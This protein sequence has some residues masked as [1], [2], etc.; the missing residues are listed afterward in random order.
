MIKATVEANSAHHYAVAD[1]TT[2]PF[3]DECFDLVVAYNVLMD[4]ED[5]SATLKQIGRVI[6]PG[7]ELVVSIVH[8]FR[9]R[10][11]FAGAEP[12]APFVLRGNYFGRQRF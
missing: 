12:D 4:V 11:D 3:R 8:P 1:A 10:G 6:R 9:D 7:G 5:V 2:H